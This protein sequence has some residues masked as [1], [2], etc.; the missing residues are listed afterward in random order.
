MIKKI[1]PAQPGR[2][3]ILTGLILF[4]SFLRAAS[5]QEI[6]Q[7]TQVEFNAELRA[8]LEKDDDI[9]I[10]ELIKNHR[11]YVKPFVD[12]LV[13]ESI[14][15]ELR[16]RLEECEK[17]NRMAAK[18]CEI[19]NRIFNEKSLL[20]AVNYL[21]TWSKEEKVKKL[22][23]D[24]LYAAGTRLRGSE[25]EKAIG[26]Y[27][28][29]IEIY[30]NINDERGES[31]I[32]GGLGLIYT[33]ID[34]DTSLV[35]YR[36]ALVKRE[37]VNDKVLIGNTLNS[38][39]SLY[40]GVFRD[41]SLALEYLDGAEKIRMDLGDSL[42]LG[43]TIHV[44]ASTLENLGQFEKALKYFNL[45]LELNQ[46]SGD[47]IRVAES[48]LKSG[49]ILNNL[50]RYEDAMES[51][52]KALELY[53]ELDDKTGISDALN[54]IGF[55]YLKMGDYNK[56]MEEF[57]EAIRITEELDDQWGLAGI[58]N[59]MGVMLQG[60]GRTEKGLEYYKNALAI[61]EELKDSASILITLN[62]T[63][64]AYFDSKDYLTAEEYHRKGL[65]LSRDLKF[66][67]QEAS[68]LLNLAN[69]QSILGKT[70]EALENFTAGFE[71]A[72]TLNSP[73]LKWKFIA[74][75][76]ENYEARGEYDRALEFND[77]ALKILEGIR[78][79]IPG[80]EFKRSYMARERFV[81]QD[82][83][84]LLGILHERDETKGY[85]T[86]AFSYE[87]QSK[88]RVLLDLL[89]ESPG[90]G[91]GET[92][93]RSE[94]L[95]EPEPVSIKE[96]MALCTDK[97]TV[98]LA[99]SAGDSSSYLW[100]ITQSHHKLFR[101]P[102][103]NTLQQQI[104]TIRF[105]LLDP[106]QGASE[107]LIQAGTSLY[108]ELIKPAEPF[109]KRN[110]KLVIIPDGVLYYLPFEVLLTERNKDDGET[111]FSD[112]PFLLKK[113][114][115][116][117][118]QSASVLKSLMSESDGMSK[119]NS[120]IRRLVAF[121]DPNYE[122]ADESASGTGK[123]Y[124]RLEYSGKEVENISTFFK[125]GD[126]E[127]YLRN[128][129]TEENAKREG[130]LKKFNFIHFAT[131]GY[132]DEDK[133]DLSSLV[134]TKDNNSEED[135]FLQA[136]EIFNLDLNADL[137]V[138]SACQTGL[139]KLVRGEGMVGLTRAFMYAG[140]PSVIVSLWSVS[141][142]STALLMGEFYKNLIKNKLSKTEA[143]RKA[144]L[145]L[146]ADKKYAHPFYWA[147]FVL[148]GDWR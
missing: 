83:I 66:R 96:A 116:S 63:G 142:M 24:S 42:N 104:E 59:N 2:I 12:A 77:T 44:K 81:F 7:L 99:Y 84:N 69:D 105:A 15:L 72:R 128:D 140:A 33:N 10:E 117:Y 49:S 136:A 58:Y 103:I 26:I 40:Y 60:V 61:Y 148:I 145:K 78:N 22:I 138:L 43:R 115:V 19:F 146:I 5:T 18:T 100:V 122:S 37:K 97:N 57:G 125:S 28:E 93:Q 133:P 94:E 51:L 124:D 36:Q 76:A 23:A 114:P 88:S 134:L 121:G 64:T 41:Y 8:A 6:H 4:F 127:I 47:W 131:H 85:D 56:A 21:T 27:R 54:Q 139:G 62:N 31:E 73:D 90:H 30:K 130:A 55:V 29:A 50:G 3:I 52:G 71:I 68:Y 75:L 70:N 25:P 53:N 14:R 132:I 80:E 112:F 13:Q 106:R 38:L 101:L 118:A 135:G 35:Y 32:L 17:L 119:P 34:Y 113:Y 107:Y 143:L 48:L 65:N 74:G 89:A 11:L 109:L 39:G 123:R 20:I 87:E 9:H 95:K 137:V 108:E 45:S 126:S 111:A 129:A 1:N 110:S 91:S 120:G 16:G 79:K 67:D 141:D 46:Q 82:I 102:D 86:L 92:A 147:P 98:I 144:R